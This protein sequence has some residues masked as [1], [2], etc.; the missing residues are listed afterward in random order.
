ML[1]RRKRENQGQSDRTY[2]H[3][4]RA[5][6][7]PTLA[8]LPRADAAAERHWLRSFSR[9]GITPVRSEMT[10]T[11]S[12]LSGV[13]ERRK[14]FWSLITHA[15]QT[16]RRFSVPGVFCRHGTD[17]NGRNDGRTPDRCILAVCQMQ[18]ASINQVVLNE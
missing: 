1:S 7:T 15:R 5:Q 9:D 16:D 14:Q 18:P 11:S 13:E 2:C 17:G 4:L 10:W 3:W 8:S 6:A 12:I